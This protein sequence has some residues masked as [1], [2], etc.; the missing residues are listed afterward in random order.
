MNCHIDCACTGLL[1]AGVM[2]STAEILP[3]ELLTL[4]ENLRN[5][6]ANLN[7]DT[8]FTFFWDNDQN[9]DL[10][11]WISF[12]NSNE[13]SHKIGYNSGGGTAGYR[14]FNTMLNAGLDV[15]AWAQD[16]RPANGSI[17]NIGMISS[18]ASPDGIYG[19][20]LD[21]YRNRTGRDT[22]FNFVTLYKPE[23]DG[24]FTRVIWL[25]GIMS[26]DTPAG[27]GDITRMLHVLNLRKEGRA[28]SLE[29][30]TTQLE[31]VFQYE[32]GSL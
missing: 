27:N 18:S 3:P 14:S 6:G 1:S 21:N 19:V 24:E 13:K 11:V 12:N 5:S 28:F 4:I 29:N 30:V 9:D 16:S 31:T 25:R 8:L 22:P 7:V 17:E 20:Y 15:D 23:A 2:N 26:K 10:D 32:F